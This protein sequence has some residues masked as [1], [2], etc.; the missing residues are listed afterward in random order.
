MS[1][2]EFHVNGDIGYPIEENY[3]D[4]CFGLVNSKRKDKAKS[5]ISRSSP[6]IMTMTIKSDDN[7]LG[8]H[9]FVRQ[10]K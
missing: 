7:D 10:K 9:E 8:F 1:S 4:Q 6:V 2:L 3:Q 5:I